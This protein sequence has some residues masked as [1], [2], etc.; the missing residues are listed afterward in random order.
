MTVEVEA[1]PLD[2]FV[3]AL[4]DG[5]QR[6]PLDPD[7]A[8]VKARQELSGL[9]EGAVDGDVQLFLLLLDRLT[10][11]AR[12]TGAVLLATFA[13]LL[14][15]LSE[16]EVAAGVEPLT[17][18]MASVSLATFT[19]GSVG[20]ERVPFESLVVAATEVEPGPTYKELYRPML[21][22]LPAGE[23]VWTRG[24]VL[25]GPPVLDG[26]IQ[27]Y[28]ERYMLLIGD[29]EGGAV[30]TF[31]SPTLLLAEEFSEVFAAIAATLEFVSAPG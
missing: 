11:A 10:A 21:V 7:E 30:L 16:E 20:E 26:P 29:G 8:L 19:A 9:P 12:D 4:P 28:V 17:S 14:P 5:W 2:A 31:N 3:L 24:L 23:A 18:V 25:A 15:D 1:P 6:Q 27:M 13:E 22:E